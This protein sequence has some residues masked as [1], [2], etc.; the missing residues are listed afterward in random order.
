MVSCREEH[1]VFQHKHGQGE[2][3]ESAHACRD[4]DDNHLISPVS[5]SSEYH[6]L[7]EEEDAATDRL[8]NPENAEAVGQLEGERNQEDGGG[9]GQGDEPYQNETSEAPTVTG[10]VS[11]SPES[12]S[13]STNKSEYSP[14]DIELNNNTTSALHL[15]LVQKWTQKGITYLTFSMDGKYLATASSLGIIFI[16]DSKTGKRIR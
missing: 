7:Y 9:G 14:W 2:S 5:S 16:F 4:T 10:T 12:N 13:T 8:H 6:S 3:G 11:L 1:T 15:N